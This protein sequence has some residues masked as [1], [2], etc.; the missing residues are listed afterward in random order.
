V[1]TPGDVAPASQLQL[2]GVVTVS[3]ATPGA[4]AP[5]CRATFEAFDSLSGKTTAVQSPQ[6][7]LVAN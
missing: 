5:P 1:N 6:R 2:R 3:S 7:F 4:F